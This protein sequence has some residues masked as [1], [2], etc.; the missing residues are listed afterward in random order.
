[1]G[2]EKTLH[3]GMSSVAKLAVGFPTLDSNRHHEMR[4]CAANGF[5]SRRRVPELRATT[6]GLVRSLFQPRTGGHVPRSGCALLAFNDCT[7][8]SHAI[9]GGNVS[10]CLK[11]RPIRCT[12]VCLQIH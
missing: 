9:E 5:F 12:Q 6:P 7:A 8:S 2:I 11:G 1:M 4:G 10:M 3:S